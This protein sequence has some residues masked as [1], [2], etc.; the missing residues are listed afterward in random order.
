MALTI[1][2]IYDLFIW[3]GNYSDEE[4]KRREKMGIDECVKLKN[5]FPFIQPIIVPPE[6]SKSVWESCA[7]VI[8]LKT[9]N[10]IEPFLCVLFEWLQ[11]MNWPGAYI[12]FDRLS[13]IPY[14]TLELSLNFSI[15]QAKRGND[16]LWS[17]ALEDFK[18]KVLNNK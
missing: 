5:L 10:E 13:E 12:I 11:D 17:M 2:E 9:N 15:E 16:E 3:D 7:K 18:K 14:S 6:K 8:S 4:Y 1:D